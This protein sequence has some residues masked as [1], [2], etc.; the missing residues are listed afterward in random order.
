MQKFLYEIFLTDHKGA[1]NSF[2]HELRPV[3]YLHI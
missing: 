3:D 1:R 2:I